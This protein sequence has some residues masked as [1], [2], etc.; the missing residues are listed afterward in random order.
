MIAQCG[1]EKDP[2]DEN[3]GYQA[4]VDPNEDLGG[5]MAQKVEKS[6]ECEKGQ[7]EDEFIVQFN[8]FHTLFLN[9]P[10]LMGVQHDF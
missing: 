1:P 8:R 5:T 6:D 10:H 7:G 3:T 4:S 2:I 9:C